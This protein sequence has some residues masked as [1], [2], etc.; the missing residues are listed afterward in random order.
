VCDDNARNQIET[1]ADVGDLI[2]GELDGRADD[3][4]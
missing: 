3:L 4:S 2:A 1:F